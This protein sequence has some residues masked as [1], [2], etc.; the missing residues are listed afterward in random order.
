SDPEYKGPFNEIVHNSRLATPEDKA[1]QTPNADT[2]YSL[3]VYDLRAEPLVLTIPPVEKARYLSVQFVDLYTF[4]FDYLGTRTTGN[5]GGVY[6]LA[7]S[8]WKGETPKGVAKVIRSETDIGLVL[9]RT[10]LFNP[11][12]MEKAKAVQAG[13]KVQTLSAH[14][15]KPAA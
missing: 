11:E 5:E 8:G 6:L 9:Y 2:L 12:D 10:Q 1:V 14:T 13:C 3:L 15:G 7:G 4:N